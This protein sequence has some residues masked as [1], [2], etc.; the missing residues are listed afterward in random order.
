MDGP[1]RT[2]NR[3]SQSQLLR[4]PSTWQTEEISPR[5]RL[6]KQS[7]Q[8]IFTSR[9]TVALLLTCDR[10]FAKERDIQSGIDELK[11]ALIELERERKDIGRRCDKQNFLVAEKLCRQF[12]DKF[13]A[14]LPPKLRDLVYAHVWDDVMQDLTF[15]DVT[16]YAVTQG[17][18]QDCEL[19]KYIR[20]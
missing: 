7:Y 8:G 20:H 2:A 16:L 19:P 4:I 14:A 6:L 1:R 5:C 15:D 18:L 10:L 9:I 17:K 12:A 11:N 13:Q 3:L